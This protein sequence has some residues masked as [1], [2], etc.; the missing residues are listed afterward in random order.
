MV[1]STRLYDSHSLLST[2]INDTLTDFADDSERFRQDQ[3]KVYLA[4]D[5]LTPRMVWEHVLRLFVNP[6]ALRLCVT[7]LILFSVCNYTAQAKVPKTPQIVFTSIRLGNVDIYITNTD[8]TEEVRLT[9]HISEDSWA[10]WSPTGDQIL[11]VSYR[12]DWVPD[13]FLMDP[14]GT[15][16][17]KVFKETAHRTRPA[18]AP[19]GKRI[20]Y[21]RDTEHAIY[22]ATITGEEE[23]RLVQV[24]EKSN[25]QPAWSPD[26]R[27]IAF[28][29][30]RH[31][32]P[33]TDTRTPLAQYEIYVMNPDGSNVRR[34]TSSQPLEALRNPTWSPDGKQIAFAFHTYA[35]NLI[36]GFSTL[37]VMNVDGSNMYSI[38]ALPLGA[39]FP[40]WSPVP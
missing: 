29:S 6:S 28:E 1:R 34:L 37:K 9:Q 5:R 21:L 15:N 8:G 3:I 20:A 7:S 25:G 31:Q 14:D 13:L 23:K 35:T 12:Q 38:P 30:N 22:T 26:G 27:Q 40:R 39:R 4:G 17:R 32:P 2:S 11:F 33:P 24:G 36:S 18:Y 10:V 16:I 19:D